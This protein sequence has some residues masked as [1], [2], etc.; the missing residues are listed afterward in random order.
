MLSE[1]YPLLRVCGECQIG[2]KTRVSHQLLQLVITTRVLELLHMDLMG[3]IQVESIAGRKY[4]FVCVDDFSRYTSV[5]F[6]KKTLEIFDV[7]KA[8]ATQIQREKEVNIVGIRSDHG[9]ESENSRFQ[10]FSDMEGI[11]H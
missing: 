2:K 11:K 8:L 5:E 3:P 6:V 10:A 9:R 7:F 4:V 1:G